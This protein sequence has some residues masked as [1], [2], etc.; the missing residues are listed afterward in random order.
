MADFRTREHQKAS[1]LN[2]L[3]LALQLPKIH[4]VAKYTSQEAINPESQKN[5]VL[6][7]NCLLIIERIYRICAGAKI[8]HL[9]TTLRVR[10]EDRLSIAVV[11][12]A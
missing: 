1:L 12:L 11:Y 8:G 3:F 5:I 2:S 7:I 10:D 9:F 4:R 6:L